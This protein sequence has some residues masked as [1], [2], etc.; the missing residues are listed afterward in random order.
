MKQPAVA[1]L[2]VL[3]VACS[4]PEDKSLTGYVEADLLYLAPQ[5]AGLV[6]TVSVREGEWVEAGETIFALDLKR[7]NYN[8]D[9]LLAS[10]QGVIA[11]LSSDGTLEQEIAEAESNAAL[12]QKTFD[13]SKLL[14]VDDAI[15]QEKYDI[16][17]AALEVADARLRRLRAE[18]I[19]MQ[20]ELDAAEAAVQLAEQQRA[21]L[22]TTAPVAGSI[23][24]IYRR[25]GEVVNAGEPVV[26]LLPPENLRV[27]FFAPERLLS[28]LQLGNDIA[29]S[30][31]GCAETHNGRISFI[32]TEP[33]FTPP[34][35]YS[36]EE[37]EK[38][39][40]LVEARPERGSA[41]RPGVPVTVLLP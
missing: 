36:L 39:V 31:S 15:S 23:E 29:F 30:C 13:R 27:K 6:E 22:E 1:L 4:D 24:R 16:D 34:L 41:L 33:Q 40:F 38:L 35:I 37:R 12:A 10:A 11:R 7:A 5:D 32:A 14:I 26:A 25:P 28:S 21:D 19:A 3:S 17:A 20:S 18:R 8:A 2:A 9:Q